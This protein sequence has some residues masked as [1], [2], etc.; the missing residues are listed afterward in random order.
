MKVFPFECAPKCGEKAFKVWLLITSKKL[1][2]KNNFNHCISYP[3]L[4]SLLLF[5]PYFTLL[6]GYN[7]TCTHTDWLFH[8]NDRALLARC[9]RHIQSVFNL[10]VDI[11]MDIHVM[12]NWQLSKRV[13]A[14]QYHLAVLQAQVYYSLRWCVFLKLS[15]DQLLVLIDCRLRSIMKRP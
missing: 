12:V 6:Y 10:I 13:S 4:S 3:L 14:D 11:L 15:A 2:E 8:C 7:S 5:F 1:L 9:P